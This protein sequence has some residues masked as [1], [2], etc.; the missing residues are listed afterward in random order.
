MTYF[1]GA[2]GACWIYTAFVQPDAERLRVMHPADAGWLQFLGWQMSIGTCIAGILRVLH[3]TWPL[4]WAIP[5]LIVECYVIGLAISLVVLGHLRLFMHLDAVDP[6]LDFS[7][8]N[9]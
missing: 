5:M 2:G 7:F 8:I 4:T 9:S 6:L 3:L 1:A